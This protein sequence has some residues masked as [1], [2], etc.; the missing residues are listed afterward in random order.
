MKVNDMIV[1]FDL[2]NTLLV[3]PD[4]F[5][6]EDALYFPLNMIYKE[7]LRFGTLSLLEEI[8]FLGI[9]IWIYTTSSYSEKYIKRLFWHYGIRIDAVVSDNRHTE[10]DTENRTEPTPPRYPGKY[11]IGLQTDDDTSELQKGRICDFK[12]QLIGVQDE[13]WHSRIIA[14]IRKIRFAYRTSCV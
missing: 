9:R 11:R 7:R 5:K 12:V 1:S 14:Q 13:K 4:E 6:A 2:D 10:E 3:S 8:Q